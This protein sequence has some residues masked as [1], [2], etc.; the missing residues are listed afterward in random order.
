MALRWCVTLPFL[1]VMVFLWVDACLCKEERGGP[2]PELVEVDCVETRMVMEGITLLGDVEAFTESD[3]H[4]QVSGLVEEFPVK[5]GD[6]VKSEQLLARLDSSQL[7]L[8]LEEM[9]YDR[10]RYRVIFEKESREHE[11]FRNLSQSSSIS[12]QKLDTEMSEAESARFRLRMLDALIRR[13][14]DRKTKKSI[15]APYDGYIV[16]EH[17]HRG[18]W[19]DA[20]GR[21]VRMVQVD[22]I[23]VRVPF[24]QRYLAKI[25]IGDTVRV[26]VDAL[27]EKV[28]EGRISAIIS[29]GDTS[30]RTFPVKVQLDNADHGLKPGMLAHASFGIGEKTASLA[31]PK[32]AVVITPTQQK[33]IY[34]V[35]GGKARLIPVR[36][37]RDT[38][39][40]VE[41]SGPS[42]QAGMQVV[43]VGNERLRPGQPVKIVRTHKA[44]GDSGPV[45]RTESDS[46]EK[47]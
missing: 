26:K 3:V 34:V 25:R 31:V 41:V 16:A 15:K 36:T 32:D 19:V 8:E 27:G 46:N 45:A 12:P 4:A 42:L 2:R 47:P 17:V 39:S 37:G 5:E 28:A 18:T 29:R 11:R 22:P 38:N 35:K 6:F 10:E 9:K 1:V 21:I 40:Y 7:V 30:S 33:V 20:G 23:Y 43:V 14:E 13:L 44:C 24:P